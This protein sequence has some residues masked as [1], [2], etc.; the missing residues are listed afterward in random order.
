M[1]LIG[2]GLLANSFLRLHRVNPGFD[3]TK[4]LTLKIDLPEPYAEPEKKALFFE[5]LQRRVAELSGVSG[6]GLVTEL[7]LTGQSADV[8]F[9]VDGHVEREP[10]NADIRSVNDGYFRVMRIP[11]LRGRS[12]SEAEVQ[13]NAK[14]VVIS[15]SLARRYFAGEDPLGKYLALDLVSKE[16]FEIVGVVGDVHHRGLDVEAKATIYVPSLRTG[17]SNLVI[18]TATNPLNLVA[19]VRKEVAAID[20]NQPVA[21]VRTMEQWLSESVAQPRFRTVLLGAFSALGLLL[22]MVGIY[23]VLLYSVTQRTKELGIRL[24]LGAKGCNILWLV[25]GRGM[26]LGLVGIGC[27]ITLGLALT[28]LMRTLLFEVKPTDPLTIGAAALLIA[29]VILVASW[30]PARRAIKID[31]ITALRYE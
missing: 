20:P 25:I 12:F 10:A 3:E 13:E 4:L 11:L 7:P 15:D 17:W 26:G 2:A 21:D 1:L 31:P 6:V 30:I 24:A 14:T 29:L 16:P 23:G 27:G 19:A 9:K 18:R 8:P 5:Q 28:Q 22:S